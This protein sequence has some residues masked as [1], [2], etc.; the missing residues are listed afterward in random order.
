MSN[1]ETSQRLEELRHAADTA[2]RNARNGFVTFILVGV[3]IA[4]II[5]STTDE[6]LLRGSGIILP[7]IQVGMPIVGVYM[8][9]PPLF[10]LLHFNL[11]LQ[12]TFLSRSL[13]RLDSEINTLHIAAD[14]DR[15]RDLIFAF[16][17][18]HL[19]VGRHHGAAMRM[20]IRVMVWI[21]L[22]ILPVALL[23]WAQVA[24]LPY[25]SE[26]VTWGAH[27]ALSVGA[28]LAILWFFWPRLFDPDGKCRP[29]R[30]RRP[31]LWHSGAGRF[32]AG[33]LCTGVVVWLSVF[34]L[35]IPGEWVELP[36][37][38]FGIAHLFGDKG[39][40]KASDGRE[41]YEAWFNRNLVLS[42]E[43][44]VHE[45][46]A[47]EVVAAYL[48]QGKTAEDA[49]LDFGTGLDLQN[50]DLRFANFFRANLA[51]ANL[52]SAKLQDANLVA[53]GLQNA[54]L[55]YANLQDA[56]LYGAKLH[57]ADLRYAALQGASFKLAMLPGAKLSGTKQPGTKLSDA[58]VRVEL[59]KNVR[60]RGGS[61]AWTGLQRV[62]LFGADLSG[63][64]LSHADLQDQNLT[65]TKLAGADLSGAKLQGADLISADLQGADLSGAKLQGANLNHAKLQGADLSGAKL[66]GA[67]LNRAKLQ[68]ADLSSAFLRG[69]NFSGAN[70]R[71]ADLRNANFEDP[72]VVGLPW[73]SIKIAGPIQNKQFD[74]GDSPRET[75]QP[76]PQ[77][78]VYQFD[79]PFPKYEPKWYAIYDK[80]PESVSGPRRWPLQQWPQPPIAD[81]QYLD[82]LAPFLKRLACEDKYVS[83]G[84]A[85]QIIG[86]KLGGR[87][88]APMLAQ[89]LVKRAG[90]KETCPGVAALS[91]DDLARL[92]ELATEL[93]TE[94]P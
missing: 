14:R 85:N 91:A 86:S 33:L 65:R 68:G 28:D 76:D 18:S 17:F 36:S 7:L 90:D 25:H 16:P 45:P 10:M 4:V 84:V 19:I 12:L 41:W 78:A 83:Q 5:G 88:G 60:L 15:E 93:A 56:D 71:L 69:A 53:A 13:H 30:R 47:P 42:D 72:P 55:N 38:R 39:Y 77:R 80:R 48:R 75:T 70:F 24:F 87:T 23:L 62:D 44:L 81:E 32:G 89:A 37:M 73:P 79:K 46:P 50:R 20:V 94:L 63:V 57:G 49:F 35:V 92:K 54:Q 82:R 3:Y 34:V 27:R 59:F 6:Q 2:A 29:W 8:F 43:T 64:N 1:E 9:V 67:N 31:G 26:P 40:G 58:K 11:L 22:M 74:R 61:V 52:I 21:T 66:Q 51:K